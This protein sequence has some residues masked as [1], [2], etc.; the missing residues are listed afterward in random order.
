MKFV[1]LREGKIHQE[2]VGHRRPVQNTRGYLHEQDCPKR[3]QEILFY[4]LFQPQAPPSFCLVIVPWPN[5]GE[6]RDRFSSVEMPK[7][8]KGEVYSKTET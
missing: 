1:P 6:M 5:R 2:I 4:S 7:H 3:R 8:T